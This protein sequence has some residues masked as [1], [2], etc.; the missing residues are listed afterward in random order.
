MQIGQLN[1][2]TY[3]NTANQPAVGS[4]TDDGAL[5][6]GA[7]Q[8]PASVQPPSTDVTDSPSAILA[9]GS[10]NAS[11][12]GAAAAGSK[13]DFVTYAVKAMRD[14]ANAQEQ[15]KATTTPASTASS[16]STIARSLGDMQKLAA[17]FKLFS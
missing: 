11:T 7:P 12:T 5:A 13:P 9:L 14:Y 1:H 16:T 8:A 4:S 2:L 17:R 10:H 6:S 3:P 15:L